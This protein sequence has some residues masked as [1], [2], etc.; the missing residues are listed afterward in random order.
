ML[1]KSILIL[2]LLIS[3]HLSSDI[4]FLG[5][6]AFVFSRYCLTPLRVFE[7]STETFAYPFQRYSMMSLF[8]LGAITAIVNERIFSANLDADEFLKQY[9][10]SLL[11]W[12]IVLG[13]LLSHD[14]RFYM[15]PLDKKIA[16]LMLFLFT[17][18]KGLYLL[19]KEIASGSVNRFNAPYICKV[20]K[21]IVHFSCN[22]LPQTLYLVSLPTYPR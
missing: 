22:I 16:V 21:K 14:R 6:T 3:G 11:A 9:A 8:L 4:E 12:P 18:L 15:K 17:N 13:E 5:A 2:F 7:Q 10:T 20:L 19:Y 1:K